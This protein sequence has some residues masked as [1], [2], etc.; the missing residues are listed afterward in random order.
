[1]GSGST[2]LIPINTPLIG[3]EEK[4]EVMKV[5]ESGLLS[6]AAQDG[7]AYVRRF[8]SSAESFLNVKHALAVNSGT[9]AL[10]AALLALD[11]KSGDEV[12]VPSFT[13]LAT[14]NTVLLAGAKPVFVDIEPRHY[15]LDPADLER[16]VTGR[17]RVVIPVHL[18][19]HPADMGRVT[20]IAEKHSLHV[21][22]DAAQSLGATY[23]KRQTGT[24]SKIG[25]FSL[26]P[27]KIITCGEGGFVTTGDDALAER[28][29]MIRNHGMVQGYDT[30][31]LGLNL[32]M[33]EMEA[34]LAYIQMSKLQRFLDVRRRN[35]ATLSEMIKDVGGVALPSEE[36]GCSSN[37]SIYTVASE[38]RDRVLNHLVSH[39]VGAAVYYNPPIHRA[40]LYVKSGLG[41]VSLPRTEWASQHVLSL[42]I[43]PKVSE[44]DLKIIASTFK[45]AVA[46]AE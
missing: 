26:Y 8:Q 45:A 37:W 28:L 30:T 22:E 6:T 20:E 16:K 5:L 13:F 11:V 3:D 19:G 44:D 24:L 25:C 33:P 23:R 32:R 35:A 43:H 9:S 12:L 7:G 39:G 10:Y 1:M 41:A 18:Y 46:S 42:P 27:S 36:E 2:V 15:T 38:N 31:I 14:A 17:S 21:I 4:A 29:K 40:P 34:A